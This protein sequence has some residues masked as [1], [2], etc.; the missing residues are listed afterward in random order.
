MPYYQIVF[1]PAGG[2]QKVSDGLT[3]AWPG[4]ITT[5]DLSDRQADFAALALSPEDLVVI[6]VPSFAGRVPQLAAQRLS[7]IAGNHARAVLLA[8]YGNRDYDDTL[9]ELEDFANSC[10]FKV[11]SAVAAVG[12][13]SMIPEY[14]A[15]RPDARDL[16]S[17]KDFSGRILEKAQAQLSDSPEIPGDRPYRKAGGGGLL[18]QTNDCCIDCKVCAK[19]CP[20]GAIDMVDVS[21]IDPDLCISC[22]R[23][24]AVCPVDAKYMDPERVQKVAEAIREAC[25]V[26]KENELYL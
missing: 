22:F 15:G 3:A 16:A 25:I 23:C 17:L 20:S 18:P 5:V 19:R 14:A 24:V 12:Q 11:I 7:R 1:S 6:A 13:H 8:V 21:K 2:T 26:R 10:G 4:E 9:V